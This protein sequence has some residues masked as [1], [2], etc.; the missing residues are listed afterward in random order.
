MDN[1]LGSEPSRDG[2]FSSFG[3]RIQEATTAATPQTWRTDKEI[4]GV[5]SNKE[6]PVDGRGSPQGGPKGFTI[7]KQADET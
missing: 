4:S 1:W 7:Q 2:H 5:T 3:G 6:P